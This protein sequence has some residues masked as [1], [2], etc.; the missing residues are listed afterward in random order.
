MVCTRRHLKQ[1]IISIKYAASNVGGNCL[2]HFFC[3]YN[4]PELSPCAYLPTYIRVE[5]VLIIFTHIL[6]HSFL[7]LNTGL[8]TTAGTCYNLLIDGRERKKRKARGRKKSLRTRATELCLLRRRRVDR[9][10]LIRIYINYSGKL[11]PKVLSF[12]VNLLAG[13]F[14]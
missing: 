4:C 3:K 10:C 1:I 9:R 14:G 12:V 7:F 11:V 8:T 5:K 2:A 6:S 13:N